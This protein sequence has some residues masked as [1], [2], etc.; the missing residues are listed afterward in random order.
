MPR[1]APKKGHGGRF[2]QDDPLRMVPQGVSQIGP[3]KWGPRKS[4]LEVVLQKW[5]PQGGS[6][7]VIPQGVAPRKIS[8]G[9]SPTLYWSSGPSGGPT[10]WVPQCASPFGSPGE[11]PGFWSP[12]GAPWLCPT[13]S[14][15]R[16]FP[17]V[18]PPF[19]P[20]SEVPKV[21]PPNWVREMSRNRPRKFSLKGGPPNGVPQGVSPKGFTQVG[22]L[23]WGPLGVSPGGDPQGRSHKGGSPGGFP[24]GVPRIVP[25]GLTRCGPRGVP[26]GGSPGAFPV[27]YPWGVI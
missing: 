17:G 16:I 6:N 20:P 24:K 25:R 11:V 21:V 8:Q 9:C 5:V 7:N 1:S 13:G 3:C 12:V 2:P 27:G 22:T 26:H 10:S 23:M 15:P 14:V 19:G 4:I 18:G